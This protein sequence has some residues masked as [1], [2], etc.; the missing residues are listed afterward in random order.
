MVVCPFMVRWVRGSIPSGGPMELFLAPA[1]AQ[2]LK[3]R[4]WYILSCLCD[5]VYKRYPGGSRFPIVI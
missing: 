3:Q 4:L 5:G 2:Q 1:S